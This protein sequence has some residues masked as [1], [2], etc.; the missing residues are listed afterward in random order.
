MSLLH[1]DEP[2]VVNPKIEGW[3]YMANAPRR[4]HYFRGG[5]ALCGRW[6]MLKHPSEGYEVDNDDSPDNCAECKRRRAKETK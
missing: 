3:T 1:N 6:M 4:W 5:R 2:S